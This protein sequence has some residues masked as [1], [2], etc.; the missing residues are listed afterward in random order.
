MLLNKQQQ[1]VIIGRITEA[2]QRLEFG[3]DFMLLDQAAFFLAQTV[4]CG[5]L[6]HSDI[7]AEDWYVGF[8]KVKA[9]VDDCLP[10]VD[11][12]GSRMDILQFQLSAAD[13]MNREDDVGVIA[14]CVMRLIR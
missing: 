3:S 4:K 2:L 8:P 7:N 5:V 13:W 9:Q 11:M 10:D 6:K 12:T 14:D 1:D